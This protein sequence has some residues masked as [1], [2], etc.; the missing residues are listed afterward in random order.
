MSTMFVQERD[1]PA[2]PQIE[3]FDYQTIDPG[4]GRLFVAG[5]SIGKLLVFDISANKLLAELPGYPKVTGVLAVPELHKIY[6]SVPG[7]GA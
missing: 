7:D 5:M 4:A 6:A 1:V 3:R 2:G